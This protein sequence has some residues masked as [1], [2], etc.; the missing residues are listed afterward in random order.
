M[1]TITLA[2]QFRSIVRLAAAASLLLAMPALADITPASGTTG[3]T[4]KAG[5]VWGGLGLY[6]FSVSVDTGFGNFSSSSTYL[7]LNGGAGYAIPLNDAISIM[8]FGNMGLAFGGGGE[9]VPITL[10]GGVRFNH[11]GPVKILAGL[12][13]TFMP[14]LGFDGSQTPVGL[15]LLGQVFYPLPQVP[16]L[17]LQGQVMVHVL[18]DST[19]LITVN[20]G[21]A[22][23]L[24]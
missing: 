13:L 8:P 24:F 12:G 23:D 6:H 7:G 20:G 11:V 5:V 10:G 2:K 22:F 18:N 1:K 14:E 17:Q 21:V 19:T 9:L 15:G 3:T 4:A 16:G